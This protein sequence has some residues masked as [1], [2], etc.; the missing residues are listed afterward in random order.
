MLIKAVI[1]LGNPGSKYYKTRHSIGFRILD[2]LADKLGG[3]WQTTDKQ[4]YTQVRLSG[5]QYDTS[6]PLVYLIKPQT[7]MNSSGQVLPFLQKKGIKPEEIV[8]AYD[9]LEKPFTHVSMHFGGG[10]KGHNGLRSI[11]EMIGKDF[12]RVRFGIGRPEE[13]DQVGDYVLSPFTKQE[14]D[15]IPGL[16]DK[17]VT[18]ILAK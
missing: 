9:E 2:Q 15:V 3:S 11:M 1:G 10:A 16:I 5:D 17:S 18:L 14:E 13:R 4:E 7:F 8:V 6:S 12:W